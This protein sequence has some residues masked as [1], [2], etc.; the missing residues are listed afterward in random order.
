MRPVLHSED[1]SVFK[2]PDFV[3]VD[4]SSDSD[5][6][7]TEEEAYSNVRNDLTFGAS[8]SQSH[9][10]S[11]DLNDLIRDLNLSKHQSE[12]LSSRLKGRNLLREDGTSVCSS[13][14]KP[15]KLL[16]ETAAPQRHWCG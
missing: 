12:V 13:K 8:S 3:T 9:F 7:H 2:Y 16:A 6:T 11:Q 14:A 15:C 4:D 1:F 10:L 5:L